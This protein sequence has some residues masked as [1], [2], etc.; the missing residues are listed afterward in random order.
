MNILS[1]VLNKL[2][3]LSFIVFKLEP[4]GDWVV[5]VAS[6]RYL[7]FGTM[8]LSKRLQVANLVVKRLHDHHEAWGRI[9][10]RYNNGFAISKNPLNEP[11][12]WPMIQ[13]SYG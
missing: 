2:K 10:F 3:I 13:L 11:F 5:S 7:I 4:G 12:H 6:N 1:P 8:D 9:D